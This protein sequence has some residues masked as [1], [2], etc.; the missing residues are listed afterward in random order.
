MTQKVLFSQ[1]HLQEK[2]FE[3]TLIVNLNR[4]DL[5]VEVKLGFETLTTDLSDSTTEVTFMKCTSLIR[6]SHNNSLIALWAL[7]LQCKQYV[8]VSCSFLSR[9]RLS[10]LSDI[11]T[12]AKLTECYSEGGL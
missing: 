5:Y 4:F 11:N 1:Y 6:T 8:I 2:S 7:K 10:G 3:R 9:C 12:Q